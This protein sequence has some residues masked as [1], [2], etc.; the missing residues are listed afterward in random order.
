VENKNMAYYNHFSNYKYK[1]IM[2]SSLNV[3][4]KFRQDFFSKVR[5]RANIICIKTGELEFVEERNKQKHILDSTEF[6]QVS[7]FDQLLLT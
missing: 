2:F 3:G 1:Q 6:Y 5:R 4:D 7:S